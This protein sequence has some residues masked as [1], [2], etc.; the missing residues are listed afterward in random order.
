MFT[1]TVKYDEKRSTTSQYEN[2][3]AGVLIEASH[4]ELSDP[5]TVLKKTATLFELAKSA[6]RRELGE[7]SGEAPPAERRDDRPP[8]A[9]TNGHA[10]GNASGN[11]HHNGNGSR[12]YGRPDP[13]TDPTPKQRVLLK[14]LADERNLGVESVRQICE[15]ITGQTIE[16]LDRKGMARLLDGLISGAAA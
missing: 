16:S 9:P 10:N 2:V 8:S 7:Q 14:K 4:L 12:R 6:V 1:I 13:N 3:T 15:R 11:G 5:E